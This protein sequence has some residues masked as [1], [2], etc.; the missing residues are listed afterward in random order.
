MSDDS[1]IPPHSDSQLTEPALEHAEAAEPPTE[2]V[3]VGT[4]QKAVLALLYP[5]IAT[6][7]ATLG[8]YIVTGDFNDAEIRV[9]IAGTLTSFVAGLGAYVGK[10]GPVVPQ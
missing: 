10:P 3:T 6:V 2:L 4:S 7:V 5:L 1:L 8:S 9:A